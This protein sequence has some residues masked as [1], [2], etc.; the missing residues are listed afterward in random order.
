VTLD[1]VTG[2]A[3]ITASDINNGSSET[4]GSVTLSV[5][6]SSFSCSDAMNSP[7]TVTLT[8]TDGNGHTGTCSS[9]VTVLNG[10]YSPIALCTS[11]SITLDNITGTASIT[12]SDINNGSSETCGSVT[13]SISQSIF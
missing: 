10:S 11:T 12:A 3:S 9:T 8:A 6:Q 5:S 1:N 13:L 4:C 2:T 7:V